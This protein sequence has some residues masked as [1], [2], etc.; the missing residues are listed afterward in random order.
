MDKNK[1]GNR[2]I[3]NRV[4]GADYSYNKRIHPQMTPITSNKENRCNINSY[5][6]PNP[7][8]INARRNLFCNSTASR[9]LSGPSLRE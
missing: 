9:W 7:S 6:S 1:I 3:I 2:I 5:L 8:T 4:K